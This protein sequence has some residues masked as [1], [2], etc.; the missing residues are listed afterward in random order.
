M[1][2]QVVHPGE[3]KVQQRNHGPPLRRLTTAEGP[4]IDAENLFRQPG[5]ALLSAQSAAI[6]VPSWAVQIVIDLPENLVMM[7]P[8]I[9]L[10]S[11]SSAN[12]GASP[13]QTRGSHSLGI[14]SSDPTAIPVRK[15]SRSDSIMLSG[16]ER[17][18]LRKRSSAPKSI[19]S[20]GSHEP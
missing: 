17:S 4:L 19:S 20:R 1:G 2:T 18:E 10:A 7:A 14:M 16:G 5:P 11:F 13:P 15:P 8:R 9:A 3:L 6:S 12:S